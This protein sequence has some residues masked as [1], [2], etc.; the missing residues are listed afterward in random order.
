VR[1]DAAAAVLEAAAARGCWI[2]RVNTDVDRK[3]AVSSDEY[4]D[5]LACEL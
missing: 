5:T 4:P 3:L 1:R 2:E